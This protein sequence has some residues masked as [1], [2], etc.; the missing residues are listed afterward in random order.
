MPQTLIREFSGILQNERIV[1]LVFNHLR[2]ELIFA[3]ASEQFQLSYYKLV[4][5]KG[6]DRRQL[7]L[8][9]YESVIDAKGSKRAKLL[10]KKQTVGTSVPSDIAQLYFIASDNSPFLLVLRKNQQLEL[11]YNFSET[12]LVESRMNIARIL[13]CFGEAIT[14]QFHDGSIAFAPSFERLSERNY[15]MDADYYRQLT[16]PPVG[17]VQH[18]IHRTLHF[19]QDSVIV[20]QTLF[21][22][23]DNTIFQVNTSNRKIVNIHFP[24]GGYSGSRI[25]SL[26]KLR[27]QSDDENGF[28]ITTFKV[29]AIH[30]NGMLQV[31]IPEDLS[32]MSKWQRTEITNTSMSQ[33]RDP[34][35]Q[36]FQNQNAS[37]YIY[38]VTVNH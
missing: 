21:L 14:Y 19:Y 35:H 7:S 17:T 8:S 32:L 33:Q 6:S 13:G 11:V 36:T 9:K 23:R 28:K 26:Q 27:Q 1:G 18:E 38:I 37:N 4:I 25:I 2:Q 16:F 24:L 34:C 31:Y 20:N 5:N 15:L 3:C 22:V 30:Q 10:E 12:L 29:V